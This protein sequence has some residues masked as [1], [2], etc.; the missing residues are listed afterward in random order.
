MFLLMSLEA[1]EL[2]FNVKCEP[3]LALEYREL[4]PEVQPGYHMNKTHWNTV[5]VGGNLGKSLLIKMINHSY[6][7]VSGKNKGKTGS[8]L[9]KKGGGKAKKH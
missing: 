5:R 1:G 8:S 9:V 7:L 4:Y 2:Q 6:E 3:Q